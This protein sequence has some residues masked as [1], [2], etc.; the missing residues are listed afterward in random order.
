M[1]CRHY[2]NNNLVRFECCQKFHPCRICHD[3]SEK[4]RANRYSVT[5]ML[6]IGCNT[7]QPKAAACGSCLTPMSSYFCPKCSL[8]DS[9]SESIFHCDKCNVCRRGSAESVAHCDYCQVCLFVE[10]PGSHMH[11]ENT[12]EGGCP[13]CAEDMSESVVSL[14][15]LL[16][17][18]TLHE[19]CYNSFV[20]ESYTCPI[21]IRSTGDATL[22]NE[23]IEELLQIEVGGE[24]AES[25]PMQVRCN[26]CNT[27]FGARCSFMY[28]RCIL[29][30]SY[31]TRACDN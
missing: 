28:N 8:W 27:T 1:A 25:T 3:A 17:G 9:S 2:A 15:L 21:C 19:E 11:V 6:C 14:V 20:R 22:M 23:K 31:N 4:H 26:D 12:A 10:G 18:H 7:V 30:K 13:I 29:C 16:C 5:H 24:G